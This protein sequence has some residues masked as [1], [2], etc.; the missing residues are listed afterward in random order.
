MAHEAAERAMKGTVVGAM[1]HA[2]ATQS[3]TMAANFTHPSWAMT[4]DDFRAFWRRPRLTSIG[5]VGVSGQ[6]HASP[7]EV[8]LDGEEF[9]LPSFRSALRI[10]D[11]R[12]NRRV[13]L[14]TWDDAW[15]AAIVYGT[16]TV[17]DNEGDIVR[18]S[19]TPTRIY[20]IRAPEGHHAHRGK[21]DS[22]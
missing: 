2:V 4:E 17:Y 7:I 15:H 19:V 13:V 16:A 14:T 10:A 6:P 3:D 22:H 8:S 1:E 9:V 18:V 21:S 5:T 20:A 12:E 11:L